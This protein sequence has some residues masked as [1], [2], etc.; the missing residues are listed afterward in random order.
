MI[1]YSASSKILAPILHNIRPDSR[2]GDTAAV[3]GRSKVY[4]D[5]PVPF[6]RFRNSLIMA[7][8]MKTLRGVD[9]GRC[10]DECLRQ[11]S[12]K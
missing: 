10:L 3:Y 5:D 2:T 8:F 1:A 4:F 12:T 9:L 6:Q 7:D 11:T